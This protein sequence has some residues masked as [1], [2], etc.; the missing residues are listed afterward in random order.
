M[1]V[2]DIMG[3]CLRKDL[4]HDMTKARSI[5]TDLLGPKAVA[6]DKSDFV[7]RTTS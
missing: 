5:C 4:T 2:D 6:D 3:V 1:Y 7:I